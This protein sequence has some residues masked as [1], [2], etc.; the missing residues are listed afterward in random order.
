MTNKAALDSFDARV[1]GIP[2][3]V[4][5]THYEPFVPGRTYGPPELCYPDEG[6]EAEWFL[7]DRRGRK[8]QWLERK[9]SQSDLDHVDTLVF[10]HMENRNA[11]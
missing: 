4:V 7:A 5:V 2:C 8:A 10:E 1:C 3:L 9:M 11:L 6:G